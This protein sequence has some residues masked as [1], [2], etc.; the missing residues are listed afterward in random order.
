MIDNF[1]GKF[2][3]LSNFWPCPIE[4]DGEQYPS[5][6]HAYQAAKTD[7][8]VLRQQV[9]K[10][11]SASAAKKLGRK[12]PLSDKW[13]SEKLELME[14]LVEQKF[15]IPYLKLALLNTDQ[16]ELIEGNWWKD[17]FWGVCA[18]IGENHLGKILM[19]VREKFQNES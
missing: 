13:E 8:P 10:A 9:S 14:Y 11:G 16:E 3:F 18:G 19:K 15:S 4:F 12:L 7:A 6:E 17:Y 5:V 2:L 1:K